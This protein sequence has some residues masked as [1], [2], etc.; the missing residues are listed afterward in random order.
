MSFSDNLLHFLAKS[1]RW[2]LPARNQRSRHHLHVVIRVV[3]AKPKRA[4]AHSGSEWKEQ[5]ILPIGDGIA[6]P[7]VAHL[8]LE[9]AD[10]SNLSQPKAV[11][12]VYRRCVQTPQQCRHVRECTLTVAAGGIGRCGQKHLLIR[13]L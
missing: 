5:I 12:L 3:V 8:R 9:V 2:T 6:L 13:S 10:P 11:K 4:C 1:I 7:S